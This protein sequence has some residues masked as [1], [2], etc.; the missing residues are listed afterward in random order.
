MKQKHIQIKSEDLY[1]IETFNQENMT[2]QEF[3]NF[4]KR[5]KEVFEKWNKES[6]LNK[7]SNNFSILFLPACCFIGIIVS[8]FLNF[9]V[10]YGVLYGLLFGVC[11]TAFI[12]MRRN[13][14]RR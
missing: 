12:Q 6:D 10:D 9:S 8:L 7:Y 1:K 14:K 5:R 3:E 4:Q 2:A 13:K 11:I